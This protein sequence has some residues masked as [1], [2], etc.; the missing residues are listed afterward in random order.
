M[1]NIIVVLANMTVVMANTTVVYIIHLPR[2]GQYDRRIR[3]YNNCIGHYDLR[4]GVNTTNKGNI[5]FDPMRSYTA[6][7]I[8][9]YMGYTCLVLAITSLVLAITTVVQAISV[10]GFL[11]LFII[12]NM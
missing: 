10:H 7:L 12:K 11:P 4:I 2:I 6:C 1:A 5:R 8:G 3:Q 9:S